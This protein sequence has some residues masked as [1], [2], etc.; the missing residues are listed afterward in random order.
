MTGTAMNDPTIAPPAL[1]RS[2]AVHRL[3]DEHPMP[4]WVYAYERYTHRLL[5]EQADF[6]DCFKAEA[7]DIIYLDVEGLRLRPGR[8]RRHNALPPAELPP[9]KP[10]PSTT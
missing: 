5:R 8:G 10:S 3:D 6:R 2:T 1:R 9:S 7:L 4:S